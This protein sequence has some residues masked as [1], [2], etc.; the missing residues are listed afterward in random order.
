M[1]VYIKKFSRIILSLFV[2]LTSYSAVAQDDKFDRDQAR[3]EVRGSGFIHPDLVERYLDTLEHRH[4][5]RLGYGI[6]KVIADETKTTSSNSN[7]NTYRIS[8][9]ESLTFSGSNPLSG[10]IL[11]NNVA[12]YN[13]ILVDNPPVSGQ[14]FSTPGDALPRFQALQNSYQDPYLENIPP[15]VIRIGNHLNG[16]RR[17]KIS[18]VFTIDSPNDFIVYDFAIVLQDPG[19]AADRGFFSIFLRRANGDIVDCSSILYEAT[20]NN[21]G[22]TR[23]DST[24]VYYRKW[25]TNV[26]KPSDFGINVGETV[27]LEVIAAD[28]GLGA[29]FGY[30]YFDIQCL[31]ESDII[32][33]KGDM[34]IGQKIEISTVLSSD[35]GLQWTILDQNGNDV[36]PSHPNIVTNLSS[37]TFTF[38]TPGTYTIRLSVDY[39]NTAGCDIQSVF[40]RR[41]VIGNCDNVC[42][43]CTSFKPSP[44]MRYIVSAWAKEIDNETPEHQ[45]LTFTNPSI[46]VSYLDSSGG[47][48]SLPSAF[49][50]SGEII[51]G[52][53]RILG[54]FIIP[55]DTEQLGIDLI[56]SSE[57]NTV[58]FDD[59]RVFPL[60]GSMKSFIYDQ[61]THKLMAEMDEN[62]YGTFYEYDM[63]GGLIRVKKETEKGIFT[64]QE[65]RS[66][67]YK[68]DEQ[69]D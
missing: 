58:Y 43:D 26:I 24:D 44:N 40:E 64:I 2:L 47:T 22:F 59:V 25:A 29:H 68:S 66:N 45:F 17:E 37:L 54:E 51:E 35:S 65:T 10:W 38:F 34:C 53:Q 57:Y 27:S 16:Q 31:N 11:S 67:N 21:A 62:N 49:I 30:G 13:D 3:M 42:E 28:C 19:H 60:D 33:T 4:N 63:E 8:G 55:A 1:H 9:C 7:Y 23:H 32:A 46:E 52:W 56:N 6:A 15:S 20:N 48:V 5:R 41:I 12:P 50:P 36:I 39:F 14:T 61:N 69:D 18:K